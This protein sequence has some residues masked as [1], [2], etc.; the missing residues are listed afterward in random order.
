MKIYLGADAM[1][2]DADFHRRLFKR[3]P[4]KILQSYICVDKESAGFKNFD[5]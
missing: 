3:L 5:D 4:A 2:K 1:K